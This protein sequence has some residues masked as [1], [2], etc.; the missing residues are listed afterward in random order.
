MTDSAID[1]AGLSAEEKRA[2]LARLLKEQAELSASVHPMSYGQR[3]QWFLYQLA[4]GS[5]AYTITYA[6]AIGGDLDVPALDRAAQA[7]VDRHAI[8]RTTYGVRDGQP[9]QRVQPRWP[10]RLARYDVDA[11]DVGDWIRR[12]TNRP[13]D[14]ETGPVFRLTLL[15]RAPRDHVLVL[16]VHHI[17]V[18]FWSIDVLLDELGKLYAAEHGAPAPPAC[19]DRYVDYVDRQQQMLSGP[20]GERLWQYWR[21]QLAGD[22]PNLGLA[23]DRPRPATQTYRGAVHRFT[24]PADLAAGLREVARGVGA[25]PY[26]TLLAAYATLLHRYTGHDDVLIGS[27]FACRDRVEME[28]LVGYVTNPVVLRADLR[29]DPTFAALLGAV[30]ETVLGALAHQDYPFP[31]LVERLRPSRDLSQTPLF[32]ASFAWEQPRRFADG[33]APGGAGFELDTIHV[34]QGGA[35]FDLTLQVAD[36]GGEFTCVLQYNT[37][38]FDDA[39]IARMAGHFT[40][41]LGGVAAEPGRRV[42]QL[43]LLTDAERR[44]QAAWNDTRVCYD[45]PDC[46]HE[47]VAA[48]ARRSPMAVAV[49]FDDQTLTYAELDAH[50][51]ALAR[52]LQ[53]VGVGPDSI[54]PVLL[55]RSADLIVALLGVLKAGGAFMPLDPA[56]PANRIAAILGNAAD[57]PACVTHHRHL[58]LVPTFRG[59]RLCLDGPEAP[60][61][62]GEPPVVSAT[63]AAHLAY[64][65]HTSGSTGVPKG[66]LNTHGAIRNLLAWMQASYR[67]T[68][69]D[70]VLHQTPITF[71]AAIGEIFW[72]LTVGARLIIAKPE[73]HK[74]TGYLVRT[75]I[76][77]SVTTAHFVPSML[78]AFL[79]EPAAARCVTLRRV[80]CGGE[81]LSYELAQ[82]FLAALDAELRNEYGPAEAAITVTGFHC[83][84]GAPGPIIPIG[85][86]IANTRV[87]LLDAHLQPVPVGVP[88]EL[89]IGGAGVGRGYLNRP[90]ATA[91]SFLADP[92]TDEPGRLMYR[93]GDL[94]RYLPDGEIEYLGRVDD[95]VK[96]RG[97]RI[98]PGEVEAALQQHPGVHENAVVAGDDGRG[99][100]G[101]GVV[102]GGGRG[103]RGGG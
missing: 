21:D 55:D 35:A 98:E 92:F 59:H 12:E 41:L 22:L 97:V 16:A 11:E 56:Q 17:A 31:L 94:A 49:S 101:R 34:G 9:V 15:R 7:L 61:A 93:T 40:T 51:D 72:P 29:G 37:D 68:P 50:A 20:E 83:R 80:W 66:A 90:H 39:T 27:P 1:I 62:D 19:P 44:Q 5:P 33:A 36:A 71:D 63:T 28:G 4:P 58:D 47:M 10:V 53:G 26:M 86:P 18:D 73:G 42:S 43:P 95:Q 65:V 70:R 103:G 67:L 78:R 14:L 45:A 75:V 96:I 85:R 87:Y 2:L 8:L 57:A 74:D 99:G 24:L 84:R 32:Q 79:A 91:A 52:R 64:V 100:G 23:T 69:E 48:A 81:V 82:Q 46:L 38:L 102:S 60:A 54:V 3:A 88:A 30:K 13:F 76:E 77:Q 25:T 6:G 89:F